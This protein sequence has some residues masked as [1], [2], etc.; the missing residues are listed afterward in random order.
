MRLLFNFHS[1]YLY[2]EPIHE[3][4]G[5]CIHEQSQSVSH[6]WSMAN[7][8]IVHITVYFLPYA[9]S[10]W[11]STEKKTTIDRDGKPIGCCSSITF[12]S[13]WSKFEWAIIYRLS[14]DVITNIHNINTNIH[15]IQCNWVGMLSIIP[16][17]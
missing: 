1:G 9:A 3:Q 7:G 14:R 5:R 12:Q 11:A 17:C 13:L 15:W 16:T 2:A 4:R 6:I 8:N 10:L